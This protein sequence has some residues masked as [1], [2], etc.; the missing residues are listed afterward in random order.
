MDPKKKMLIIGNTIA[1]LASIIVNI[2]ANALPIGG[3]LTAD[4]ADN[5]PNLFVPAGLTFAI[6]GVIYVLILLFAGY[7]LAQLF[8]KIDEATDYLDKISFW[9]ILAC[10]GN[11][12]WIFLWHYEQILLSMIPILALFISLLVAYVRLDIGNSDASKKERYFIHLPISVYLGW[13]TV[14]TIANVT[15][16]LVT[17]GVGDLFLGEVLWTTLVIIVAMIITLLVIHQKHDVGYSLV[18]IWALLG[19]IIKQYGSNQMI[20][21]TA[22]VS[23]AIIS[24][25]LLYQVAQRKQLI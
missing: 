10:I 2:L 17:L 4:I 11:I 20:V 22:G 14:A 1:V 5:I 13:L 16:V 12:I 25:F 8:G 18:I 9:F 3:N 7:Q 23:A 19:I 21:L 24:G 6:W 15:A